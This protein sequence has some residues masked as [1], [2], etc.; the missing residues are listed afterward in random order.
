MALGL[1]LKYLLDIDVWTQ[2]GF[3][4]KNID[5][6]KL[7]PIIINVQQTRLRKILGTNLYNKLISDTPTF[8]GLYLTLMKDHVLLYMIACCDYEYTFH[9][10]SQLTNKGAGQFNDENLRTNSVEQNN[11]L[12]DNFAKIIAERERAMIGWL[13]DQWENIPEL[14]ESNPSDTCHEYIQPAKKV[15]RNWE[16]I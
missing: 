2:Y 8:S 6:K 7:N 9:G 12:R 10:T 14:Y 16:I 1:D 13:K 5:A 15:N 11:D 4:N 3:V